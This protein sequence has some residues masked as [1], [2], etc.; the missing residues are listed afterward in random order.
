M[1]KAIHT[2][3]YSDEPEATRAFLRDVLRWPYIESSEIEPGWLIFKTGPSEM[4][5]HP[6]QGRYEGGEFSYPLHHSIS[7]ICDDLAATMA[8]LSA[9]GAEFVGE[10]QDMGFGL[11]VMLKLPGAGDILLYEARHNEAYALD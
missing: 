10:S 2:L 6:T 5:V 9:R 3:I 8:E 11:G 7:L 1:I 4:G